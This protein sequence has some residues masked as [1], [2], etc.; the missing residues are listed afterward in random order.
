MG[1][2][3]WWYAWPVEAWKAVK[4]VQRKGKPERNVGAERVQ[5]E[6]PKVW[7]WGLFLLAAAFLWVERKMGGMNG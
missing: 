5:V 6:F 1:D 2:T 3:S 7:F 4:R